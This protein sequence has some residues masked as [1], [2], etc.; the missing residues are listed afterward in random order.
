MNNAEYYDYLESE[1]WKSKAAERLKI[2]GYT[3]QGCGCRGTND[4]RLQIHHLTYRNVGHESVYADLVS[5]CR[6]C[7]IRI[8][9]I[10]NRVTDENGR[11]GWNDI[12]QVPKIHIFTLS[13]LDINR[14][15]E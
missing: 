9:N 11:R 14:F 12:E 5:L 15:E 7:H 4:N 6:N 13:G 1:E 3:C 10:M 8:H 2:D